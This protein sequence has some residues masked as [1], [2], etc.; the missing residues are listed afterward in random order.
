MV[1]SYMGESADRTSLG[2]QIENVPGQDEITLNR[3]FGNESYVLAGLRLLIVVVTFSFLLFGQDS[4][5][6]LDRRYSG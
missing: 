2:G 5:D 1:L 4:V 6:V 3:K